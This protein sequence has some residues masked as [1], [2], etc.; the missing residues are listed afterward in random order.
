M[1]MIAGDPTPRSLRAPRRPI[2]SLAFGAALLIVG[3]SCSDAAATDPGR[4]RVAPTVRLLPSSGA[5]TTLSFAVDVKDN[6]GIK[7]ISVR[8]AGGLT[9]QFDSNFH[10]AVT[11]TMVPFTVQVP[12]SVP[13]GTGVVITA[14]AQDG[15]RN[16]SAIDTLIM[17][18]GNVAPP[19][20]RI[21][22][23]LAS[24]IAVVGRSLILSISGR[25][26]LK[27]RAL[28]FQTTGLMAVADSQLFSSPLLDSVA[29]LDTLDIPADATPG[30][31][32]LTPFLVD[33][34]GQRVLGPSVVL[35]VQ[36]ATTA[37]QGPTV[38]FGVTSR[39]EVRDTI[40][41]RATDPT[42]IT[43]L[44]YE[45][46]DLT[47]STLLTQGSSTSSGQFTSVVHTFQM[48]L[49]IVDFPTKV[50]VKAYAENSNGTRRY[51]MVTSAVERVDTVVVVAGV[52]RPLPL[53]GRIADGLYH[54]GRDRLYLTNIDRHQLEVFNLADSTF[55]QPVMVGSFPWG[56]T[57]WP[58]DR[59]GTMGD[60]LLVANSGGTNISYVD[61]TQ[62][63]TGRDVWR[64]PLPNIIVYSVTSE[65][66]NTGT[67]MQQR[68]IFD[69]SDRP[70][71]VAATCSGAGPA[72]GDVLL[73]YSTSPTG[74]QPV[75]F[76][77]KGTVR[78]E[79][80]TRRTSHFFFEHAMG[81]SK[82]RAD[83]LEIERYAAQSVGADSVLLPA[84]QEVAPG[85]YYSVVVRLPELGF[86]DTTF[87]RNSGD[88]RRAIAGEG[89][90]ATG[91]RAVM[92]DATRGMQTTWNGYTL[93]PAVI[94]NGV[95]RAG[96]VSDF[97]V[98]PFAK[99]LGVAINFDGELAAIRGD[100]TY[101]ID[102]TLRLQGMLQTSGGANAG[103]DFHPLNAGIGYATPLTQ[104]LAFS[105]SADPVIEVFDTY[106]YQRVASIPLRDPIVGPIKSAFRSS[107]IVLVGATQ[108]G[109][110]IVTLPN[111]FSSS[112]P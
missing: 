4:D 71:F 18:V 60:T 40:N 33:S 57:V 3:A 22:S 81:Q 111:T 107:Q 85:V 43:L 62:G 30:A 109:V 69:F 6:L 15:A 102:P 14:Q 78:Y 12:R 8:L 19:D 21:T 56:I 37:S 1:P 51:A 105:A 7:Q 67:I 97:I 77:R 88:F 45:V 5:D 27:I 87:V 47:G 34:L 94:D 53:G 9:A 10:T 46:Y 99:V 93:N 44:G 63:T 112:C 84:I 98:N 83:T 29:V 89:G 23:P 16:L 59:N 11:S 32:S 20:V 103:F 64:Y 108:R 70:Q 36:S 31:L 35:N 48:S 95:S 68:T 38:Q 42:G 86:R 28:G 100:S 104:R 26:S 54:S 73:V 75:P 96:D 79:N 25:S 13:V 72:C 55:R 91:S 110:V 39:I 90:S 58:R 74:G 2:V 101:L 76:P 24:D 50:T 92:F 106:C 65:I 80:L 52:T 49:P 61:L 82:G 17:A 66:S 41:V